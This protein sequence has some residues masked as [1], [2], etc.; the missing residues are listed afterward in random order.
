MAQNQERT[1]DKTHSVTRSTG[2]KG[3]CEKQSQE[4][5]VGCVSDHSRD[6]HAGCKEE[7]KDKGLLSPSS[8]TDCVTLDKPLH[9]SALEL[10][11]FNCGCMGPFPEGC[12]ED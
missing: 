6:S 11:I 12:C 1:K 8:S 2:K 4:V 7:R 10:T 9:L 5:Q 3:F